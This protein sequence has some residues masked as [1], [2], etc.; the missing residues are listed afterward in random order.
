MQI[1]KRKRSRKPKNRENACDKSA[2]LAAGCDKSA[3]LAGSAEKAEISHAHRHVAGTSSA[4]IAALPRRVAGPRVA[5]SPAPRRAAPAL[6]AARYAEGR[7]STV[8]MNR[9]TPA[10]RS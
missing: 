10:A 7:D 3:F 2:F 1:I 5:R 9:G 8:P 4:A 6:V